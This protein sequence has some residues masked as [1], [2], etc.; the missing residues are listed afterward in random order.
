MSGCWGAYGSVKHAGK[1]AGP[2]VLLGSSAFWLWQGVTL[3]NP[4][5]P[6]SCLWSAK[7]RFSSRTKALF[8]PF[9]KNTSDSLPHVLLVF[10]AEVC[11]YP[12]IESSFFLRLLP[13]LCFCRLDRCW[14]GVFFRGQA[15]DW[16]CCVCSWLWGWRC[17]GNMEPPEYLDLDEIDFSEDSVVGISSRNYT[18][19]TSVFL[20]PFYL[21][22]CAF[23]K[24]YP[25][26]HPS[27]VTAAVSLG[28]GFLWAKKQVSLYRAFFFLWACCKEGCH[29]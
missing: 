1:C 19:W 11:F 15:T 2:R 12:N 22:D 5:Y 28:L 26:S 25:S 16:N 10:C 21:N 9:S 14:V 4:D 8:S 20:T 6:V 17:G 29:D 18:N 13:V 27:L 23:L 24:P 7:L 3:T